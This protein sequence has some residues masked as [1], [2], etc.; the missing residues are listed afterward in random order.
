MAMGLTDLQVSK[1]KP[2]DTRFE[3]VDGNGLSLRITPNGL[4]VWQFRY[5]FNG[6]RRRMDLG[7]YPA[8]SLAEART[9]H[10][11][12]MQD[13]EHSIDPGRQ[14][15]TEKHKLKAIPNFK[16]MILE[17]W[18]AELRHKRSG[19]E[20]KR[21][22]EKDIVPH[23]G[24]RK[25]SEIKR[26][27]IVLLLDGIA[28]RGPIIR[29]RVHSALTRL[30]NF[31]AE[32]G[33]IE[34]SP[35][36]RIRKLPETS[37]T[38]VLMDEEIKALW[39][40]LDLR[41]DKIDLFI[42]S[43]LCLKLILLTGQRPGEIC[44]MTWNELD[45]KNDVWT[46]PAAR[47]K[48]NLEHKLPLTASVKKIIQQAKRIFG[49][50]T[51]WVFPSPNKKA[52]LVQHSLSRAISRHHVEMGIEEE[53]TPHDIRRTMR[54]RLAGLNVPEFIAERVLGHKLEGMLAVYNQ[55]DYL[56]EKRK[57]LEA[58]EAKLKAILGIR[59]K[60]QRAKVI[61]LKEARPHG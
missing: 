25:V 56:P 34:D 11:E 61:S 29:N 40:A 38:R 53:F 33:V 23:W 59:K 5:R 2:R 4:K 31:S 45:L 32:R 26:R 55:Y 35:C 44:G 12:A 58:W 21:L 19:I 8:I 48:N 14:A 43:K 50:D 37:K 6:I 1:T 54:T 36:T 17:L 41:N 30:F 42:T 28:K 27:D 24:N 47:M 52:P 7:H 10:G 3:L 16:D 46:I 15:L 9:R 51:P 49:G 18:E 39:K 60:A 57:A 13:L 20:T 22:L